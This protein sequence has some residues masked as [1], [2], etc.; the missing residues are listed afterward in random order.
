MEGS[1][2]S[3]VGWSV[4]LNIREIRSWLQGQFHEE[5]PGDAVAVCALEVGTFYSRQF[6]YGS[7]QISVIEGRTTQ[8]R[9]A[10]VGSTQATSW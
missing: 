2:A 5:R 4:P 7:P 10:E 8:I 1:T 6:Q 3:S 9:A